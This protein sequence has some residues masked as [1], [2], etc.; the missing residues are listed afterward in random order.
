LIDLSGEIAIK[1]LAVVALASPVL[2]LFFREQ[3][4]FGDGLNKL[5]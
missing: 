1:A 3:G 2:P 5:V 4:D